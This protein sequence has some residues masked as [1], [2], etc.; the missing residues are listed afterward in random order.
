MYYPGPRKNVQAHNRDDIK[1]NEVTALG[2]DIDTHA[3]GS[4]LEINGIQRMQA[5]GSGQGKV[6]TIR[7]K[8][9]RET[10]TWEKP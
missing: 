6:S 9:D 2:R 4:I 8:H 10:F 3:V 1:G 7:L 5:R